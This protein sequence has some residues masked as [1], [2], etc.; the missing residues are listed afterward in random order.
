MTLAAYLEDAVRTPWKAAEHDCSAWPARWAGIELPAYSTD[1]EGAALIA[2][3]GGLVALWD[4][5][6]GD[7]LPRADEP[8]AGDVGIITAIGRGG[9]TEVGAIFTGK[10]WAFATERGLACVSAEPVAVWRVECPK[11]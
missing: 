8:Q 7:A 3:A 1:E 10:R 6:I 5:C 11:R 9:A 4:Y 2:E